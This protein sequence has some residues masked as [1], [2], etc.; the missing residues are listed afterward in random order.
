MHQHFVVLYLRIVHLD[1]GLQLKGIRLAVRGN[2]SMKQKALDV[3]HFLSQGSRREALP[4]ISL[5][6]AEYVL[7][8]WALY[9]SEIHAG[10]EKVV[11]LWPATSPPIRH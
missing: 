9:P 6:Q 10:W 3:G 4:Q 1:A 5:Q 8:D 2:T 11:V 7:F